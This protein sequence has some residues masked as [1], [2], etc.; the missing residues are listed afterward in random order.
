MDTTNTVFFSPRE[1]AE[2]CGISRSQVYR[3]L[4]RGDL[5]AVKV[6][7]RTMIPIAAELA[8]REALP[9]WKPTD[10]TQSQSN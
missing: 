5:Q 9:A 7:R 10:N 6:G 2:R 8:W 3:L 1:L 4:G